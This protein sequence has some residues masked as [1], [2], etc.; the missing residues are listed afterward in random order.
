MPELATRA[1]GKVEINPGDMIQFPEGLFGFHE[2]REFALLMEKG[3]SPFKWLQSTQ[4]ADLAFIVIEPALFLKDPYMPDISASELDQL[5]VKD[6]S[7]CSVYTIVTIPKDHPEKMT[8]NLQGPVL[9]N[10]H[11]MI[12]RQVISNDNRHLVR[13]PILEQ[14]EG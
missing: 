14:M 10:P 12:G 3:D 8:A 13:V 2:V 9:I 5:G 1:L 11:K 6:L 4:R 7:E